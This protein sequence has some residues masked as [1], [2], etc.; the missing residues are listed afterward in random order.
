MNGQP[1]KLIRA[2]ERELAR[3]QDAVDIE[4]VPK[5]V[6]KPYSKIGKK[7]LADVIRKAVLENLKT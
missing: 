3:V 6:K 4:K 1:D 2:L 7:Y 5:V